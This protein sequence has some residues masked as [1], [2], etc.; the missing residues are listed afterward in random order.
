MDLPR[1]HSPSP[2]RSLVRIASEDRRRVANKILDDPRFAER[3][4]PGLDGR[5]R[6]HS[7]NEPMQPKNLQTC[8]GGA[9]IKLA[10]ED[11]SSGPVRGP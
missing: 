6:L 2:G 5:S 3:E 7:R 1:D 9:L 8:E 11:R 10:P 4:I